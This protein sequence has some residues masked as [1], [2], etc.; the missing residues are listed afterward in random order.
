MVMAST[1]KGSPKNS[2]VSPEEWY[3]TLLQ[4]YQNLIEI[5]NYDLPGL[6]D[7]LEFELSIQKILNIKD[8][9]LP[10]AGIVLGRPSSLKTV[11]IELFRKWLHTYYTDNFSARA[12]VSHSTAVKR[13]ALE[14][15]DM[16]P[17]IKN[18]LFLTPELSPTF[19]KKDDELIDVLGILTRVLDGH[20]Y[21]S[22]TGAHGH[23]GYNEPM[24]FTWIG[25]AVDIP[26]K[27]H[28]FLGT[29]GPK[30]YFLRLP[31]NPKN[32][33]EYFDDLDKDFGDKLT[34]VRTA[35]YD[36]LNWF[37]LCPNIQRD[38][39]SMLGKVAWD[40]DRETNED[41][42]KAKKYIVKLAILLAHLRAVVPTWETSDPSSQGLDYAYALA[43]IE[44][45]SRAI[46][47]LRNLAR[48]HALSQGRTCITLHDIPLLIKVVFST[49]SQERVRVFELL[50]ECGGSL[51]TSQITESLNTSN[52]TAKRTM[53]ELKAVGLVTVGDATGYSGSP[54][55]QITLKDEYSWFI[56]K[57]FSSV[58]NLPPYY[59]KQ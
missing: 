30:L 56:S 32:E 29:L 51:I 57:D 28:K 54:E 20:G 36:Y 8:C 24:M 23:R 22:D 17:K 27:V 59:N 58:R 21:E 38:K 46:T 15:I 16:L 37:E 44:D 2:I 18:K 19:S 45:P 5:A 55:K 9:T 47:Q 12:F 42:V 52:N 49:A 48:G 25:A 1:H 31:S 53:A 35:L 11:G 10:F 50:I 40:A 4:R 14:D 33:D 7:S 39:E 26:Y 3:N 41:S 43:T 6:W 13:E 34:R